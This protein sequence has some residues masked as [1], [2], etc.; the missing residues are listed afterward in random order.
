[1]DDEWDRFV[2]TLLEA[3]RELG[4]KNSSARRSIEGDEATLEVTCLLLIPLNLSTHSLLN[5]P[6]SGTHSTGETDLP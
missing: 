6:T 4:L 1:M 3:L 2:D 5:A